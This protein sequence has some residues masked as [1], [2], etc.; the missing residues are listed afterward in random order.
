M[1]WNA[2]WFSRNVYDACVLVAVR[3]SQ[4]YGTIDVR[5]HRQQRWSSIPMQSSS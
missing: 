2:V 1:R 3:F 4:L 5:F